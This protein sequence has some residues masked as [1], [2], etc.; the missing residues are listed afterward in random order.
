MLSVKNSNE[1]ISSKKPH[2]K[3]ELR[4]YVTKRPSKNLSRHHKEV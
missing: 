4:K 1:T 2:G 3:C